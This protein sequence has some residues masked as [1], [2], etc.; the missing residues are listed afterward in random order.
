M[1][2]VAGQTVFTH[3]HYFQSAF[4]QIYGKTLGQFRRGTA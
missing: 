4:K 1:D 2:V 3:S